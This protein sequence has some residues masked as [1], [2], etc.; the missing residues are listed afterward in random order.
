MRQFTNAQT[1]LSSNESRLTLWLHSR[2]SK[3]RTVHAVAS[4]RM[5]ASARTASAIAVMVL[6]ANSVMKRR[7]ELLQSLSGSS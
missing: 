1:S 4:A 3:H 2:P 5:V 7:K 6:K